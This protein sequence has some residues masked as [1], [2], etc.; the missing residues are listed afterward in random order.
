MT[1]ENPTSIPETDS[2]TSCETSGAFGS[3]PSVFH[4]ETEMQEKTPDPILTHLTAL[5][6]M[7]EVPPNTRLIAAEVA[8][9]IREMEIREKTALMQLRNELVEQVRPFIDLMKR[10]LPAYADW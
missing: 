3:N 10:D 9:D 4:E 7:A 6:S 2:N 5:I 8:A 1:R